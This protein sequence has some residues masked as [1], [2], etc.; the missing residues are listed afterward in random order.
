[1]EIVK[2][3]SDHIQNLGLGINLTQSIQEEFY[4]NNASE[5]SSEIFYFCIE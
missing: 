3:S 1:M 2:Q 4:I 5:L